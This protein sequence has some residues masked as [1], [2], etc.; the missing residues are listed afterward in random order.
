MDLSRALGADLICFNQPRGFGTCDEPSVVVGHFHGQQIKP[1]VTSLSWIPFD[2]EGDEEAGSV[3]GSRVGLRGDS[4]AR[5]G[6]EKRAK[7]G[8]STSAVTPPRP[9]SHGT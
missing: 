5:F 8:T 2:G 9:Q 3:V 1:H 4:V 6:K 7:K